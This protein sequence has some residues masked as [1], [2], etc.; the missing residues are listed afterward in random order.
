M[1]KRIGL[2][3]IILLLTASFAAAASEEKTITTNSGGYVVTPVQNTSSI[4][5]D[6]G[7]RWIYDTITQGETNLHSKIVNTDITVLNVDLNWG[8]STDS[9][10]LKIHTAD[11]YVLGPYF[12][13]FD[14]AT[15]GRINLDIT[16][17]NG[18]AKGT[19]YYE[20]YGYSVTGT[21][22]YYI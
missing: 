2:I 7:I 14:G 21:E 3:A 10:R 15:D 5:G 6:I 9:L 16:N 4:G 1:I 13:N 8:D 11:G 20:V 17:P 12:D 19:W 18:I 22:N